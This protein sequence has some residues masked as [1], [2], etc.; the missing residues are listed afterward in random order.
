MSHP[1]D[2]A[3]LLARTGIETRWTAIDGSCHEVAEEPLRALIDAMGL[4]ATQPVESLA[5]LDAAEPRWLAP[6]DAAFI[7]DPIALRLRVPSDLDGKNLRLVLRL[8]DGSERSARVEVD[9]LVGRAE[10]GLDGWREVALPWPFEPATGEHSLR[11][12]GKGVVSEG[13]L[14]IAPSRCH[15]LPECHRGAG[16][17]VQTYALHDRRRAPIGDLESLARTAEWFGRHGGDVVLANPLGGPVN[18]LDRTL[19][20]YSPSSRLLIDPAYLPE[21]N[22]VLRCDGGD[23]LGDI[24]TLRR[25]ALERLAREHSELLRGTEPN[26]LG[27]FR[28]WCAAESDWLDAHAAF[29]VLLERAACERWPGAGWDTWPDAFRDPRDRS[30]QTLIAAAPEAVDRQR[31]V[32][33]RLEELAAAAH[34]RAR[35]AGLRLGLGHDLPLGC[36]R[37]GAETWSQPGAFALG[38]SIGAPPD[39]FCPDGQ[40]WGLPPVLPTRLGRGDLTAWRRPLLA[41]MRRGGMLRIDHVMGL[42]RMWWIPLGGRPQD[43]AYVRYPLGRLLPVLAHDSC[44]HRCVV[45]GEDLGTVEPHLRQRLAE[46]GVLSTRVMRFERDGHGNFRPPDTYPVQAWV[47]VGTHDL[48]GALAYRRRIG[49][50]SDGAAAASDSDRAELT[51]LASAL[52]ASGIDHSKGGSDE[53]WLA[54]L[55]GFLAA[56]PSLLVGIQAEDLVAYP[57][58]VN[59]PGTV[60]S[61]NWS[62]RLAVAIEDWDRTPSVRAVLAALAARL[63]RDD[64]DSS[65]AL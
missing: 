4:D 62:H 22:P 13:Q 15:G 57:G 40:E 23:S 47:T 19:A 55:H 24:G 52:H 38:A 25:L 36:A 41:A 43:G 12:E 63:K 34:S 54:A 17:A 48:P 39:P 46:R 60:D 44:M 51:A 50:D 9:S 21:L 49:T 3:R 20:P 65:G 37:H 33:W 32:I 18:P 35:A 27:R 11:L 61:R 5:A 58:Q 2:L 7:D 56:T 64:Q 53:A 45:V 16:L 8:S 29:G 10:A 6:L 28:R 42:D 59:V 31:Y 26:A 30:V 14:L 1:A